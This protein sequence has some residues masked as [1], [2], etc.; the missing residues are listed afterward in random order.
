MRDGD[1][2]VIG[3]LLQSHDQQ[4]SSELSF[5]PRWMNGQDKSK[6][7]IEIVLALQITKI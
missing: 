3:G 1:V 4:V 2:A 7:G 5:L 6:D